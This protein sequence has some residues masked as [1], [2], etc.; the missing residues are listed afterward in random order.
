MRGLV[1]A[2]LIVLARPVLADP[3][4]GISGEE[5]RALV[6][7]AMAEAGIAGAVTIAAARP[8]PACSHSPGIA[9]TVAGDW[10]SV[11]L[12]CTEPAW[13]RT[14]R[15]AAPRPGTA[16]EVPGPQAM[17]GSAGFVLTESLARGTVIEARHLAPANV[18]G[19]AAGLVTEADTLLGRRLAVNMSSGRILLARHLE[20]R[21]QVT[22]GAPV[23]IASGDGGFS[24]NV[25]GVALADG[26]R[27]DR[28]AVRNSRSGRVIEAEVT[29]PDIVRV[30][31]NMN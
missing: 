21:W 16:R 30:L 6:T 23:V 7:E 1:L 15:T 26:Q 14:L 31:P 27:G 25:A 13:V 18:T 3:T 20:P 9:P 5:A 11:D 8:L 19:T 12:R 24:V 22:A 28:I 4:D 2:L 17:P 29:G 10:R